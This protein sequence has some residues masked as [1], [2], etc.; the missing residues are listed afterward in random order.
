MDHIPQVTNP[1]YPPLQVPCLSHGRYQ[2]NTG[3]FEHYP[4]QR[5]WNILLLKQ[6]IFTQYSVEDTRAFLQD[7]LFFGLLYEVLGVE[8]TKESFL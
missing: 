6:C 2:Q 1:V 5:S 4:T 8:F 7:W 3:A